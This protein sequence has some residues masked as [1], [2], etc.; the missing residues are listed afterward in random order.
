MATA[1][2]LNTQMTAAFSAFDA[3]NDDLASASTAELASLLALFQTALN[4]AS[5]LQTTISE[6]FTACSTDARFAS[7]VDPV[8]MAAS[9]Q[10]LGSVSSSTV[11]INDIVNRLSRAILVIQL[12]QIG[13][14]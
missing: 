6:A 10:A 11:W 7:G 3:I 14:S 1:A 2:D 8:A 9:L 12:A 13:I 5:A 4:S